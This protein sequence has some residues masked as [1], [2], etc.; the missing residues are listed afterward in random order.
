MSHTVVLT[1]TAKN[2]RKIV[3]QGGSG[4]WRLDANRARRSEFLV[5]TRNSHNADPDFQAP[6]VPHGAAFLI[7]RI[8][9]VVPS[10]ADPDRWVIEFSEYIVCDIPNIWRQSQ[11]GRYPVRYTTLED[12]GIDLAALPPFHPGPRPA[13]HKTVPG[14]ADASGLM[15]L[16]P[17]RIAM[18]SVAAA[19]PWSRLDTILRQIDRIPD[20]PGAFDPLEWDANGL[21]R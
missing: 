20:Q 9:D 8:A 3:D 6:N 16:P 5:C 21:P 17:A 14:L 18:P 15:L 19:D 13:G 2:L 12:L 10:L 1:F 11:P 4:D 7:G